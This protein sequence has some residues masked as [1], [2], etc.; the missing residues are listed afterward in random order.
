MS[1]LLG[2]QR[3][4]VLWALG[5][6]VLLSLLACSRGGL[7][8][9]QGDPAAAQRSSAATESRQQRAQGGGQTR[10]R[11]QPTLLSGSDLGRTYLFILQNYVD[12]VSHASLIEAARASMAESFRAAGG[13]P[14]DS[15]PFETLPTAS[16]SPERDWTPFSTAFDG[17]IQRHPEWALEARPD[18]AAV[19][20]MVESLGDSHSSF[21]TAE[22]AL[23]RA[24]TTYFGIGVRLTRRD[25]QGPPII[26]EVFTASPAALA[27]VRAGDRLLSVDGKPVQQTDLAGV[28]DLIRGPQGT[29]VILQLERTA[30]RG[31]FAVRAFRRSI[32]APEAEG[33]LLDPRIGYLR[34]RS[35]G[36]TVAERT[37]RLL[38]EHIQA[39]AQAW[40][41]DLRGNPG[42]DLRAVRRV[43]G[44]FMDN[45]PVAIAVDRSGQREALF[46]E[47]RP[48][49]LRGQ[50]PMVV[51]IDS[52][53]GSATELLAAAFKEYQLSTLIGERTA[54]RV[55]LTTPMTN[56][57]SD[58]STINITVRRLLSASGAQIDGVGIQPDEPVTLTAQDLEAGRDPQRD[59]AVQ[60]LLQRTAANQ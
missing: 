36:E 7:G 47:Q 13:L 58:G 54:G 42:G 10:A 8:T 41:I 45:R 29:E 11:G 33:Q 22:E 20:K 14:A 25:P 32:D 23:R 17:A 56:P 26:E 59:R 4:V 18:Y 38:Q 28:R 16:G 2:R 44:Y 43:A 53:S 6:A 3:R 9:P 51:L 35:F 12:Q 30:S 5:A 31:P 19:R 50:P 60:V 46:S 37:G 21:V 34:I 24:E 27:G 55:G 15:A 40:I 48:F 49:R 39:G 52:V 1:K 57:L